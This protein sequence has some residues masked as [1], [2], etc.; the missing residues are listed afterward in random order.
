[1]RCRA[2]RV[3]QR[4][5]ACGRCWRSWANPEK[6]LKCIHIAGTNGK[7]TLAAMTASILTHAGYKTGLTI[8]P[9]CFAFPRALSDQ[10]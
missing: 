6:N 5:N 1:M 2:C 7:G 10:R 8:R 4:W 9:L 3:P